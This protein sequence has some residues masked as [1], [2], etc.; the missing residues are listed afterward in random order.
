MTQSVTPA[1]ATASLTDHLTSNSAS[2]AGSAGLPPVI[3]EIYPV[4]R[5]V[6]VV[7]EGLLFFQ[8]VWANAIKALVGALDALV[9]PVATAT[10][11]A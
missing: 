5:P 11:N 2:I 3:S 6:L 8:P 1:S 7:A 10:S 4:V 9:A